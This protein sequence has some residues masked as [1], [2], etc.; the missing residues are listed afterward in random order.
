[1]ACLQLVEDEVIAF[2]S[3]KVVVV[4]WS[5]LARAYYAMASYRAQVSDAMVVW[6]DASRDGDHDPFHDVSQD[7]FHPIVQDDRDDDAVVV[8]PSYVLHSSTSN[9]RHRG[10]YHVSLACSQNVG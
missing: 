5:M 6:D 10:L 9:A 7:G 2:E 3:N 8:C 1:M 4:T